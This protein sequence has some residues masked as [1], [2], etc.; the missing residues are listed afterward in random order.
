MNPSSPKFIFSTI[1]ILAIVGVFVIFGLP[2]LLPDTSPK[3]YVANE[4]EGTLLVISLD[5]LRVVKTIKWDGMPHN[6]NVDP[7]GRYVYATNHEGEE[8]DEHAGHKMGYLRIIDAKSLKLINSLPLSAMAAHA[9][10]SRDGKVVYV[11]IEGGNSVVEIDPGK[12]QILR[13]FTV[14]EGPHGFVL[15]NDSKKLYLPNMRSNDI[16][17][18]DLASSKEERLSLEFEGS[19]CETPVA[20]G[21]TADDRY[22]FVTCGR[23]FEIYKIDNQAKK[24]VSR[25]AL[26][27][28]EFPGPIQTPV[29]PNGKFLY[30]PEMRSGTVHKID[31]EKFSLVKSIDS[32]AGAHGIAFSADGKFAYVT[33]TWENSVSV[34]DLEKDSVVQTIKVGVKPNGIALTNGKNQG[35]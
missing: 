7:L 34:L 31:I 11:S 21:L 8:E 5:T 12:G 24:V 15:S 35:W 18:V 22:S 20:M 1:L 6:V 2:Q 26:T 25:I 33:N 32:G 17:I 23:S 10:P 16:S 14:G 28:G 29:H 3:I 19:K 27:K 30:V 4:G 13:S 9:V